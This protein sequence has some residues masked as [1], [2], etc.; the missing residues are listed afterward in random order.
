M[1]SLAKLWAGRVYGTNT[2]NVFIDLTQTEPTVAGVFRFMDSVYGVCVYD[3]TGI[4]EDRLVLTGKLKQGIDGLQ[5]G[6]ITV[7]A[8]LSPEGALRGKWNTTLGTGGTFEAHPHD[9]NSP[10]E[11]NTPADKTTVLP[12]E[13]YRNRIVKLGAVRLFGED[14][15]RLIKQVEEDFESGRMIVTY[16]ERGGEISRY[17][18]EFLPLIDSLPKLNYLKLFISEPEAHG[19]NKTVT[20]ELSHWTNEIRVQ[21]IRESWVTGKAEALAGVMRCHQSNL[22]T[23]FRK[24]G[25]NFNLVFLLAL[26]IAM[27]SLT[28][29]KSRSIFGVSVALIVWAVGDLHSRFI[30]NTTIY[31]GEQRPSFLSRTWPSIL[32][33]VGG[34]IASVLAAWILSK[35]TGTIPTL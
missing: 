1:S 8:R 35:L 25:L 4:F 20:V 24:F 22:I 30:P 23:S 7:E 14:V 6:D 27:P 29:W 32:S 12:P 15:Q 33:W 19:L 26:I 11:S 17:V 34:I 18:E 31:L 13:Q 3:V 16:V 9:I 21:G 28:D 10:Q 5:Y 2:G